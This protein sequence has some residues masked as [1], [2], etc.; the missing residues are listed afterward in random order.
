M[1]TALEALTPPVDGRQSERAAAIQRGVGRLLR[2][3]G[4]AIVYELPLAT[5]RRADVGKPDQLYALVY[6][7]GRRLSADTA[8][9]HRAAKL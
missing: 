7:A 1:F 9:R 2:A 6:H 5:G 8:G 4:F 3:R